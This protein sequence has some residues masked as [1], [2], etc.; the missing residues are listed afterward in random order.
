MEVNQA[1]VV[2]CEFYFSDL[3]QN[4]LRPVVV[5]KNNLP[6]NDFVGVPISSRVNRLNQD[7]IVICQSDFVAGQ[8]PK[9]SKVMVRKTF[10]ISKQVVV[11]KYGT[12]SVD[13]FRR[14]HRAFCDYF[15]CA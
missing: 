12:L 11:K 13:Y 14:L 9:R 10:V 4:K 2:L 3:K 8:L 6:F 15:G 5:F 1:E 7:E